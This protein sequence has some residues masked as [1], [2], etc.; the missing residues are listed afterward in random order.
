MF[1]VVDRVMWMVGRVVDR[2]NL[3]DGRVFRVI[4]RVV[5]GDL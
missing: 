4:N 1:R 5:Q 2:V 3:V